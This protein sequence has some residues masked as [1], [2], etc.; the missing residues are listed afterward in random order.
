VHVYLIYQCDQFSSGSE[1]LFGLGQG[2]NKGVYSI[3]NFK[4]M[5]LRYAMCTVF[6]CFDNVLADF[7]IE[8]VVDVLHTITMCV[9]L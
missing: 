2:G 5:N 7:S 1:L 8:P 9:V 3:L 6:I 4:K